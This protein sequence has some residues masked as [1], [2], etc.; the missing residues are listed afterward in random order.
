MRQNG[1]VI[2]LLDKGRAEVVVQRETACGGHC[3]ACEACVYENRLVIEA[4]N[5]ICARPGERVILESETGRIVGA[6]LLVYMLPLAL[7]FVCLAVGTA[8]ALTQGICVLLSLLGA[9]AGG[10]L[11]VVLGRRHREITFRITAYDR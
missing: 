1:V 8:F 2:K 4:D 11:A 10:V 3:A 6:A 9:V 7:F 5:A